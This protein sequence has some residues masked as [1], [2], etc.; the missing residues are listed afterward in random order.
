MS[1][2]TRTIFTVAC[3]VP[4]GFGQHVPFHSKASLLDADFVLFHPNLGHYRAQSYYLGKPCL[5]D[6]ASFEIQEILSHWQREI[7]DFVRAGKTVFVTMGKLDEVYVSTGKKEHSGTGK[8]RITTNIVNRISNYHCLPISTNV[9]ES[10]GTSMIL[11]PGQQ[12]LGEYW[13]NF[14][15]DSVYHVYIEK[16]DT[17]KPLIVTRHGGRVVGAIMQTKGGGALV[18]L[19]WIDFFSSEFL[20]E[21]PDEEETDCEGRWTPEGIA[22]GRKYI[23]ILESLDTA[24]RA[25]TKTTSIPQWALDDR[26]GTSR[27]TTLSEKLSEI[28]LSISSFEIV[29]DEVRA[30][31][32]DARSL[33]RLLFEQGQ[34]LEKAIL[35]AMKLMGFEASNYRDS[36]SEFDVVLECAEGRCIGE[37]E[38]RDRKAI[39]IEKM[40][41]LEVNIHEDFSREDVE[42]PAKGI[43]FGNAYRLTPPQERPAEQFTKKCMTAAERNGTVLIR[44]CEL[45]EVAR[46]LSDERDDE[47]A[48][49]CR[50]AIFCTN[51]KE[52]V[53]HTG[54][55]ADAK[56]PE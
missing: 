3:D 27:E 53:F 1:R 29:R 37:A 55:K 34:E 14:E 56:E 41:Q 4:G 17:F 31:L 52:I 22:W 32:E 40:R 35:E 10:R 13:L 38:G 7:S 28:N 12:L 26:Y 18:A 30:Q 20:V 43:L 46:V 2:K 8:N 45:F 24:I 5:S 51:G 6:D 36:D 50:N 11:H 48:A 49:S 9:I 15:K 19:P 23:G 33:R 54:E 25:Q 44:T 39:G 21:E 47:L 42:E 16:P